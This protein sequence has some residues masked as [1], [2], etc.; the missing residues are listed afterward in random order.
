MQSLVTHQQ[1]PLLGFV[2]DLLDCFKCEASFGRALHEA[3]IEENSKRTY[4]QEGVNSYVIAKI[5]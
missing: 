5:I 4:I 3:L 1:Y 2:S